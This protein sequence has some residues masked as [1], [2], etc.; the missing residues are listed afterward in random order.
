MKLPID[1]D[2]TVTGMK[3][4]SFREFLTAFLPLVNDFYEDGRNGE[5]FTF[6]DEQAKARAFEGA[7]GKPLS[8]LEA[9]VLHNMIRIL[10]DAYNQ[11]ME[12]GIDRL[13]SMLT[14][15]NKQTIK[16]A[17]NALVAEQ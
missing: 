10:R 2:G 7:T 3:D 12:D 6:Q 15:E 9:T 5:D 4:D 8:K 14:D 17:I 11:G 1:V 13:Y 16:G